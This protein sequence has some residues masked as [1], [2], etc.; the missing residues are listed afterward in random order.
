MERYKRKFEEFFHEKDNLLRGITFEDLITTL[1]SN[2]PEINEKT[3]MKVFNEMWK[4]LL[5]EAQHEL[6]KD[7]KQIIK[8]AQG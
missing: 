2:E 3:V 8:E 7:M 6:K 5:T 1:Q 4:E